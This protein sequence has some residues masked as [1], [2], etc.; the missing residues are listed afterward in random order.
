MELPTSAY[1]DVKCANELD[2]ESRVR[3]CAARGDMQGLTCAL[4]EASY[5]IPW[6][7]IALDGA[8]HL[9]VLRYA[10][11]E[12]FANSDMILED[13]GFFAEII[14]ATHG[15]KSSSE[16]HELCLSYFAGPPDDFMHNK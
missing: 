13:I 14:E 11:Q 16:V 1:Q 6:G 4:D 2:W 5:D 15:D 8:R 9:P 10:L 7:K 12:L 3:S